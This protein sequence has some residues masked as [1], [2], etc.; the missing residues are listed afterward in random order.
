MSTDTLLTATFRG[1]G[2][3]FEALV[4][5]QAARL[6]RVAWRVTGDAS[7]AEDVLQETFLRVLRVP[8]AARPARN[9]ASWLAR[10]TVR[11]ALNTIDSERARS[12]REERYAE[13]R[14]RTMRDGA[15]SGAAPQD[16]LER[17]IAEALASL[18][19]ETRAALWLHVVE[20]Q[21]VREV[22]ACL[23]SSRSAVSRRVRAGLDALR[24]SLV[25]SGAAI[26]GVPA[27]QSA[28]RGAVTHPSEAL[29]EGII[30]AGQ[31]SMAKGL[32]PA[33]TPDALDA[34]LAAPRHAVPSGAS[35]AIAASSSVALVAAIAWLVVAA[36]WRAP[37]GEAVGPVA[38]APAA[39][40]APPPPSVPPPPSQERPKVVEAP[41]PSPA[42]STLLSGTVKDEGG[43][44]IAGATVCLLFHLPADED[45]GQDH[46]LGQYFRPEYYRRS[47]AHETRTDEEGRFAFKA[48]SDAGVATLSAFA[49]GHAAAL[50]SVRVDEGAEKTSDLVLPDGV[51]LNG[52]IRTVDG[53]AVNDAIISV[54]QAWSPSSHIFR[55]AG[56]ALTDAEGRFVLGLGAGTTACHLRVTS[57]SQWQDFFPELAVP[58]DGAEVE[59]TLKELGR[60]TGKITWSGGA[61]ASGLAVRATG[62]LSEPPIPVERMGLGSLAVHD[63]AVGADGSYALEG[64]YPGL[65]YDI[66]VIDPALGE[67]EAARSPLSPRHLESFTVEPGWEKVWDHEVERPITIHGR[68][69]TTAGKPVNEGQVGILKDGKRQSLISVWADAEGRYTLR[70]NT[71]PG[72]YRIHAEP[73]VGSPSCDA[74]EDLVDAQLGKT[75][76][77]A[78]HEDLEVDLTIYEPATV[79]LR[80][81]DASGA[82]AQS[83]Q[84][85]LHATFPG[86]GKLGLDSSYALDEEGRTAFKLYWPAD[87]V[88][89]EVS[90][91]RGGPTVETTHRS[92]SAGAVLPEETLRLPAN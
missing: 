68:I 38:S 5:S 20:G 34:A 73:P 14:S 39:P 65:R 78:G 67:K 3:A 27:L 69:L 37:Q 11:V 47:R 90:G 58:A 62:R 15:A 29:V 77:L 6:H 70:L 80:V 33:Q 40:S 82:P 46:W 50:E 61:P 26:A 53:A 75:L 19:P 49:K 36:P 66:F 71:G 85:I 84:A 25:R 2:G 44:P 9:A 35:V 12:R 51:T 72:E 48:L 28:L 81:L 42:P 17:P 1:D 76:V 22:A 13:Q 64:L 55:G 52:R 54:S 89:F 57:D 86:G 24:A 41:A 43:A 31:A 88:W 74:V 79:P 56:L 59:L 91:E 32:N 7:L 23:D 63:A 83:I 30:E 21:G 10:V 16:E 92:I 45:R 8:A 60:V 4:R 18:S 87:E